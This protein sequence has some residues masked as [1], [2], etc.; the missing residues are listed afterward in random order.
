M[1]RPPDEAA[2]LAS[3]EHRVEGLESGTEYLVEVRAVNAHGEG[4]AASMTVVLPA[5]ATSPPRAWLARFGRTASGHVADAIAERLGESGGG[6]GSHLSLGGHR[7][8]V[9]GGAASGARWTLAPRLTLGVEGNRR[10]PTDRDAAPR[11]RIEL[12]ARLRW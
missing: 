8:R 5:A 4:E 6:S 9:A 12:R 2:N 10:E 3:S 7:L 11:H 1:R